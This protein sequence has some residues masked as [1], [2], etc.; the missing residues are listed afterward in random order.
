MTP[1][2]ERRVYLA[3]P[4]MGQSDAAMYD[5]RISVTRALGGRVSNPA[6]RDYRGREDETF[7]E[8]VEQDKAD[9]AGCVAVLALVSPPSAGTSMEILFAYERGIPV[10][11]WSE[12]ARVSPWV[13]YHAAHVVRSRSDAVAAVRGYL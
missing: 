11:A 13:R 7:R 2:A 12:S 6:D 10:V 4:I 3:G 8:I 5:W 1:P 9:I